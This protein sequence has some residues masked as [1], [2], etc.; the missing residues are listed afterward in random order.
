MVVSFGKKIDGYIEKNNDL[1]YIKRDRFI[2]FAAFKL[3]KII[4]EYEIDILHFHWTKD[5]PVAV[6]AKILSKKKPFLIQSRHMAMT[7]FKDDFYHK[8]LYKQ[9]DMIHA[10]TYEVKN[11]LEKYIPQ[12]VRPKIEVI[13]IGTK[14]RDVK[15][16]SNELKLKYGIKDD[17]FVI[18]IVGRIEKAKGQEIVVDCVAKL[19]DLPIKLL[20]VGHTMDKDYLDGIK[21]KIK[22]LKIEDKVIFSGFTKEIDEHF[23]LCDVSIMATKKETFGLVVIESMANRVPVIAT[24]KGGPLEIITDA[25]DGLLFDGSVDDLCDKIKLIYNDKTLKRNL[26]KNAYITVKNNFDEEKQLEKLYKAFDA[27]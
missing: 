19:R 1:L 26:S 23:N 11:Q 24:N 8:F 22:D 9:I 17:D 25:K 21:Q 3:A 18:G 20:I 5:M 6:L 10:V 7:R 27:I 4:D 12:N 15:I 14:Q 16:K 13:Y 2:I